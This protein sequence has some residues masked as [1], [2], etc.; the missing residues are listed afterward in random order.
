MSKVE[1]IKKEEVTTEEVSVKSTPTEKK[2]LTKEELMAKV[3]QANLN[4]Q[5]R[6][7]IDDKYKKSDKITRID[8]DDPATRRYLESL[9]YTVVQEEVQV[10]SG[11]LSEPSSMGSEVHVEQG[12]RFSQPGILY[13]IDKDLYEARKEVECEMNNEHFLTE[14]DRNQGHKKD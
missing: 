4:Y 13:E 12:I 5:G 2:K 9:G 6:L 7:Y 14:V 11:S 10:G 3:R 8:N 1:S